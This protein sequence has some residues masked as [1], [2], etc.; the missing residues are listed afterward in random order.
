[1]Q[2]DFKTHGEDKI[3]LGFPSADAAR[4][5]Y[6]AHRNDG[7]RAVGGMSVMPLDAFKRKLRARTGS[8]KIRAS[9]VDRERTVT[10]VVALAGRA[11]PAALR[12]KAKTGYPDRLIDAAT[13][14]ASRALVPY[15]T[16]I[17]GLM[18][19]LED[20]P[21]PFG[22]LKKRLVT[23]LPEARPHPPG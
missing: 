20:H 13:R 11:R 14:L 6:V 10:A 3:M 7:E 16:G 1:M 18:D 8:G 9:A 22:E 23:S 21:D 12:A 4:A 17:R 2:N 19:G 15:V 5:A